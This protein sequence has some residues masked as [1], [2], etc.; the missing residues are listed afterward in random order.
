MILGGI[1]YEQTNISYTARTINM[2]GSTFNDIVDTLT[3]KRNYRFFLPQLQVKYKVNDRLSVR[4]AVTK[5]YSRPGFEDVLP[6][7]QQDRDELQYGN[8]NLQYPVAINLDLFGEYYFQKNSIISAGLFA[9]EIDN[10]IFFYVVHGYESD[11]TSGAHKYIIEL[12]MNGQN[13]RVFGSELLSQFKL[14]FL[15]GALKN[16]GI[17]SNYTFTWSEASIY[18]RYPANEQIRLISL[19]DNYQEYF[20]NGQYETVTLPGQAMHTLNLAMFYESKRLYAKI[21]AN[22]HD[23]F[24]ERLGADKDLDEYYDEAW[25]VDLTCNYSISEN[26]KLFADIVNITNSPL[27]FYTGYKENTMKQEYYSWWGR[28]GLK[29]EL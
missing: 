7:R 16:L 6:Y 23:A 27:R 15:P 10:F 20:N 5:S 11:P 28:F 26:I 24:L 1:R 17:Y 22:Y 14:D 19:G 21:S 13:A 18:K 2:Q 3:D 9:K 25:H 8:P 29:L 12:P 4:A